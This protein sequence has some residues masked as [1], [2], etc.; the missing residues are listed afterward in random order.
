MTREEAIEVIEQ[1]IPC[2]HD[3]DLIEALDMA[4]KSLE[5]E[6]CDKYITE[7]DHLRKY[8]SKLETQIVEQE[9]CDDCVSRQATLNA[10]IKELCIKDENYLLQS[11]K[12]IYN[13]VKNMLSVTPQ[14]PKTGHWTQTN[15]FFINRDGQFIYKFICSECKS[16]S[17]FRK[18][19]KKAIGAN[20][21]PNCGAKMESEVEE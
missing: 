6:S 18:S 3:T 4:I 10:I 17:Y 11:E 14:E 13:V 9:P 19:N 20:V 1:D 8:I 2:E 15:E 16:L 12:T 7:I 5:Q 21:C